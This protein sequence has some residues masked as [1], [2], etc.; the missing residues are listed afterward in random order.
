MYQE[1]LK[2]TSL[3]IGKFF[4]YILKGN[5]EMEKRLGAYGDIENEEEV[6]KFNQEVQGDEI[7]WWITKRERDLKSLLARSKQ[8]KNSAQLLKEESNYLINE[9]GVKIDVNVEQAISDL[10]KIISEF[11]NRNKVHIKTLLEYV[12]WLNK[13]DVLAP[14]ILF[15]YRIW[16]STRIVDRRIYIDAEK[17][18]DDNDNVILGTLIVLGLMGRYSF[19]INPSFYFK[20]VE[21]IYLSDSDHKK[22]FVSRAYSKVLLELSIFFEFIRNSLNN[23]LLETEKYLN[24][25]SLLQDE[26]FWVN[27]IKKAMNYTECKLWDF[28]KTLNM[29][30]VQQP[31]LKP[32]M[33]I[34]FCEKIAAFANKNGGVLII[35]IT[36]KQPR[37]VIGVNY[38]ENKMQSISRTIKK[39]IKNRNDFWVLKEITI[40]NEE[41]KTQN[42]LI[43]IVAQTKNV[44]G[45]K[46]E[47]GKYSYPIRIET[48]KENKDPYELELNKADIFKNNYD[49]LLEIQSFIN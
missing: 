5:T 16:G 1:F 14:S 39:W 19:T 42:C 40:N 6:Q 15:S 38:I 44:M 46:D 4:W 24:Q 2:K 12:Q 3:D 9:Y 20:G 29:W 7:S 8:A 45:V 32:K 30:E 23:I 11:T 18:E 22:L 48:G 13:K 10:L 17:V 26:V 37:K 27:F 34:D 49:F 36:D 28:K 31:S 33:Q 47:Q 21:N 25:L 35:G 43:I 41:G